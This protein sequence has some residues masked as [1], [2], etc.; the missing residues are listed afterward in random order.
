MLILERD[1]VYRKV[2]Y[3]P[4]V[5]RW[6]QGRTDFDRINYLIYSLLPVNVQHPDEK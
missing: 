4:L 6:L 1:E 3:I 5:C 2:A